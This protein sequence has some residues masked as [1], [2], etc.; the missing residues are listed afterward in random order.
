M[1]ILRTVEAIAAVFGLIGI[2][3]GAFFFMQNIHASK[4]EV[5]EV[6]SQ[7]LD[8]DIKKDAEARAY[9]KDREIEG[10]LDGAGKRRLEYLEEQLDLKYSKQK[11]FQEALIKDK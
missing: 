6:Q 10:T 1:N 4:I 5:L 2:V 9:Y 11:I 3:F 8:M 7:V